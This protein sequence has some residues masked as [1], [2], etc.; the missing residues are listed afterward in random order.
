MPKENRR[1]ETI[2]SEGIMC[3][4]CIHRSSRVASVTSLRQTAEKAKSRSKKSN[5]SNQNHDNVNGNRRTTTPAGAMYWLQRQYMRMNFGV[6][7]CID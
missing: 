6:C 3:C 1:N 4:G 5:P 7:A 2:E